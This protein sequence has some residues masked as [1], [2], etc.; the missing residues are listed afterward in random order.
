[1]TGCNSPRAQQGHT[2]PPAQHNSASQLPHN[3][4]QG[5]AF[6]LHAVVPAGNLLL[7]SPAFPTSH[8]PNSNSPAH[9]N[10]LSLPLGPSLRYSRATFNA[11]RRICPTLPLAALLACTVSATAE[12]QPATA[13]IILRDSTDVGSPLKGATITGPLRR[14]SHDR[15]GGNMWGS[16]D[17]LHLAGFV[18]RATPPSLPMFTSRR[19]RS[20]VQGHTSV[21]PEFA[22]AIGLCRRRNPRRRTRHPANIVPRP[23][24]RPK[25]SPRPNSV[26]PAFA[27][28][29][30]EIAFRLDTVDRWAPGLRS[31]SRSSR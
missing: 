5:I 17:D 4:P 13:P 1:M 8:S 21:S 25:T 26:P 11:Q 31:P 20:P 2:P 12:K 19:F 6:A 23:E 15:R 16:A 24:P 9:S 27:S 3:K 22:A 18:R 14:L 10:P 29:A 7:R 28:S 30:T